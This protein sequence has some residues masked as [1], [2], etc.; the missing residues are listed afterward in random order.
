ML[1]IKNL[2]KKFGS[3]TVLHNISCEIVS[4]SIGV[5]L[6]SSG[7]GK[8]TL[9]RIIA[10]LQEGDSGELLLNNHALS[11]QDVGMV[12]QHFNLFE[13]LTVIENIIFGLHKGRTQ[14]ALSHAEQIAHDLLNRY[15]LK[16]FAHKFPDE[17][18]GGQKQRLALL[19][20]IAQ[21]PAV[22]CF[23]EPTSALDPLLKTHVAQT[24]IELSQ[25]GYII[26][27][28]THDIQLVEQLPCIIFLMRDG[29]IVQSAVSQDFMAH[30]ENY[31]EIKKFMYHS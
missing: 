13:N 7:T 6:G 4:G 16:D 19:R 20:T 21:K 14:M 28:A 25:S 29:A 2:S 3:K 12:F 24:L 17:L 5:F 10:G 30:P 15:G 1:Q 8:S 26:V 27:I 31:Q 22:I 18:S 23:D 9:L 11:V